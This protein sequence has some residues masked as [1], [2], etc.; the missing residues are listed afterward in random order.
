[1]VIQASKSSLAE[2]VEAA[3]EKAGQSVFWLSKTT[4]IPYSTLHRN[5]YTPEGD[6]KISHLQQ[7]ADAL[8]VNFNSLVMEPEHRAPAS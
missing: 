7:I 2:R 5:L 1:M 3:L 4:G 6:F 8:I